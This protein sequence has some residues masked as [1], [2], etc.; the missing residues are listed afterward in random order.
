MIIANE[1]SIYIYYEVIQQLEAKS[2][3]DVGMFLK[4]I[5]NVSRC[6]MEREIPEDVE[7]EGI[8]FFPEFNLPVWKEIY[9]DVATY[10]VFSK[11]LLTKTY[12]LAILLGAKELQEKAEMKSLIR[13]LQP[14]VYYILVDDFLVVK[15]FADKGWKVHEL[16][17]EDDI[18]YLID[19]KKLNSKKIAFLICKN[20]EI[21]FRECSY[22]IEKL[23]VPEGYSVE[24]VPITDAKSMCAGYNYGMCS[25]MAKYKIY[26]HQDVFI[27]N[28]NFLQNILKI[29]KRNKS[30]GMI[31]MI[32]GLHMP[33]TG[34][35]YCAWNVGMVDCREPDMAYFLRCRKEI[36][37]D[38]SVEA[39]DGLLMATQYDLPWR[40]DLLHNFDFY[41][42]SQSFEMRKAGYKV[43]VP[44]QE[45]PWVIHDSSF[46]KLNHYDKNRQICLKEYADF[47][48]A[49]NGFE[50]LYSEEW[51]LL[52]AELSRQV[53]QMMECGE[54]DDV[55]E[56][57]SQYRMTGKKDSVLEMLGIMSDIVQKEKE[58][59]ETH[60]FFEG[61]TVWQEMYEKYMNIRFLLRRMEL[62]LP[63]TE[64][65]ELLV[66]VKE[67][68]I[69]YSA[70]IIFLIRSVV[71]KKVCME[72][73]I[74][75]YEDSGQIANANNLKRI[76]TKIKDTEIPY[77][78]TKNRE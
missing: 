5:G 76:Y 27:R 54:W 11:K 47:F 12:D 42:V 40:E 69:S 70:I 62:K 9:H 56:I 68:R 8:D 77:A 17:V 31:G 55:A 64:Y 53:K 57:I 58:E 75:L 21:M 18:Y 74:K 7:L 41:D 38:I 1:N 23:H 73:L 35:A 33:K 59:K 14:Y 19:F 22:Y 45:Q 15:P 32:G 46:A 28:K 6:A 36:T 3:L 65:K 71:D 10:E 50:F 63:E 61:M 43:V 20:N 72:Q 44:Y 25:S 29:F 37:E 66:S 60:I 30:V 4:R 34:V 51:D 67:N 2:V 13:K 52:S 48:Y 26:M 78:Y 49:E 39:I 24:I 16:R